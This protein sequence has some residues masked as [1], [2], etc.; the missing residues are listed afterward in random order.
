VTLW[1]ALTYQ[2]LLDWLF[3]ADLMRGVRG[4]RPRLMLDVAGSLISLPQRR[5]TTDVRW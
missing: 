2:P 1:C 3:A 5:G 4:I